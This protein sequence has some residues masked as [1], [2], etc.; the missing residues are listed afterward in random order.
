MEVKYIREPQARRTKNKGM[1]EQRSSLE[2]LSGSGLGTI[3]GE[4]LNKE[5]TCRYNGD[6]LCDKQ[7]LPP[8]SPA[9][10]ILAIHPPLRL[11]SLHR[12][13]KARR[14]RAPSSKDTSSSAA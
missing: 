9:V 11:P 3:T 13:T 7:F 14:P 5:Q 8:P 1:N 12:P 2:T 6:E 10:S 4:K